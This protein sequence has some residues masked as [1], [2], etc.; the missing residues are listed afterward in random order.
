MQLIQSYFRNGGAHSEDVMSLTQNGK[1]WGAQ[2]P[3]FSPPPPCWLQN[4]G[5]LFEDSPWLNY[6][7]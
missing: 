2:F 6:A 3:L 4:E 7:D 1:K 5:E